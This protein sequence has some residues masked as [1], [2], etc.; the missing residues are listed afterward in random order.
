MH[1]YVFYKFMSHVRFYA[2]YACFVSNLLDSIHLSFLW[3]LLTDFNKQTT[4]SYLMTKTTFEKFSESLCLKY[5]LKD[6]RTFGLM[7]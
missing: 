5:Y 1:A 7:F 4:L 3:H 6:F 2:S